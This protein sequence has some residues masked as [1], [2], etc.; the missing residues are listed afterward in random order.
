MFDVTDNAEWSVADKSIATISDTGRVVAHSSGKTT[1][2]VTYL[3][4]TREISVEVVDKHVARV[5]GILATPDF[6]VGS[7]GTKKKVEINALYS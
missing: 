6:V 4:V 7:I 1:I 3:G 2:S 5:I